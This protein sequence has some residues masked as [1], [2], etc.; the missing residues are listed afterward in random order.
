M[1]TENI[2]KTLSRLGLNQYEGKVFVSVQQLAVA[3][4]KDVAKASRVPRPKVYEAL[5]ALYERGLVIKAMTKP[6]TFKPIPLA[7]AFNLLL[8][9][10]LEDFEELQT[11][12]S[13]LANE[14]NQRYPA[15]FGKDS[16]RIMLVPDKEAIASCIQELGEEAKVSIDLVTSWR[17]FSKIPVISDALMKAHNKDLRIRVVVQNPKDVV[18]L[19]QIINSPDMPKSIE[20]R[21]IP[22]TPTTVVCLYDEKNALICPEA[23]TDANAAPALVT[24]NPALVEVAKAY[25]DKMWQTGIPHN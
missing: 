12:T 2:A 25:F 7:D 20:Y 3:S 5:E 16:S 10:K 17:R 9:R 19:K 13:S 14:F 11:Q 4:A 23:Q 6:I 8:K 22:Q 21:T 24:N 1:Q 15:I 18:A